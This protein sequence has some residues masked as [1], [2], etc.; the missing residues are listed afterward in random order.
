MSV[1][2]NINL[3]KEHQIFFIYKFL[4]IIP[5]FLYTINEIACESSKAIENT[6]IKVNRLL[7]YAEFT[8]TV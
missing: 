2:I 8:L 5:L 6:M 7:G 4:Y 3:I 1:P